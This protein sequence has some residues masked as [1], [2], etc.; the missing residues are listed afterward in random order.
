M[1]KTTIIANQK[2]CVYS[3]PAV[4]TSGKYT[5]CLYLEDGHPFLSIF[6]NGRYDNKI[7]IPI[8]RGCYLLNFTEKNGILYIIFVKKNNSIGYLTFDLFGDKFE[9]FEL[10]KIDCEK[11]EDLRLAVDNSGNVHT[12][13]TVWK[14][15]GAVQQYYIRKYRNKIEKKIFSGRGKHGDIAVD[16][17]N[18]NIV[19]QKKEGRE[20]YIIVFQRKRLD[21]KN[22]EKIEEIAGKEENGLVQRPRIALAG[23]VLHVIYHIGEDPKRQIFYKNSF[24]NFRSKYLVSGAPAGYGSIDISVINLFNVF[25]SMRKNRQILIIKMINK[26]SDGT[27]WQKIEELLKDQPKKQACF[28]D[29]DKFSIVYNNKNE[30]IK[31]VQDGKLEYSE[32]EEEPEE[33]PEIEEVQPAPAPKIPEAKPIITETMI[34]ERHTTPNKVKKFIKENEYPIIFFVLFLIGFFF[35]VLIF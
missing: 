10:D 17:N 29:N 11:I 1:Q 13:F 9:L 22:W 21:S 4:L 35:G 8:K 16:E 32:I 31:L 14:S 7:E 27:G 3:N 20:G 26:N 23:G 30:S 2:G 34:V 6:E 24:D 25:V 33:I 15:G 19:W 5:Y 18:I 12:T 28:L